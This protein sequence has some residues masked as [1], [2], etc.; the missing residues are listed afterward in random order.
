MGGNPERGGGRQRLE[1]SGTGGMGHARLL[2]TR[3]KDGS[4]VRFGRG[5]E[6]AEGS[7][8]TLGRG[9]KD[10]ENEGSDVEFWEGVR[11]LHGMG[12]LMKGG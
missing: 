12:V 3:N 2:K 5:S 6:A 11:I 8:E 10:N 9:S 7:C 4:L 1:L